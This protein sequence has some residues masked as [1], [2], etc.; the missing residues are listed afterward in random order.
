MK[1]HKMKH[2]LR[3][4]F[5]FLP[6]TLQSVLLIM[7]VSRASASDS[8]VDVASLCHVRRGEESQLLNPPFYTF[9]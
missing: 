7:S 9:I 5:F 8:C 2:I 3:P 6:Q 1:L 4:F